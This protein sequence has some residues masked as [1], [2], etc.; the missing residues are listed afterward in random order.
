MEE[1]YMYAHSVAARKS[2]GDVQEDL[3]LFLTL[4][5]EERAKQLSERLI[6]E[7]AIPVIQ[8]VV[9]QKM[10]VHLDYARRLDRMALGGEPGCCA[11]RSLPPKK[12]A[13]LDAEDLCAR[14][15]FLLL[16][17]LVALK[18]ASQPT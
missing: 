18:G 2:A 14:T 12:V 16:Q 1:A 15:V 4:K 17:H 11:K 5:D 7:H 10:Q 3:R 8:A 13:E 9:R 6:E